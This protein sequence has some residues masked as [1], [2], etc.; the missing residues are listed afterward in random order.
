M[1]RHIWS[2]LCLKSVIDKDTN[3]ITLVEVLEQLNLVVPPL[4]PQE[5][6]ILPVEYEIVSFFTRETDNQPSQ[7][8]VR[9]TLQ[10]PSGN[11]L[12]EPNQFAIDLSVSERMRHRTRMAGVPLVG[13]GLYN[14]LVEY[15]NE[16]DLTWR[17]ATK[18]PL[19][20]LIQTA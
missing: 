7:G 17:T 14:F 15:N 10:G 11:A 13:P 3:N 2:V 18:L 1:L 20:I 12:E 8:S 5:R 6:N 9:I 16:T 4:P 19:Q